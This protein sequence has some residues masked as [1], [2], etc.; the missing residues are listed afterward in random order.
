MHRF[1]VDNKSGN[2]FILDEDTKKHIK[3]VRIKKESFLINHLG[4]YYECKLSENYEFANI[5]KKLDINNEFAYD[6][7]LLAPI[8][9]LKRFEWLIQ[10]ATELGVKKIVPFISKFTNW[11]ELEQ[12][13]T[14]KYDRFNEIILNASQQSFRN[15]V[16]LLEKHD[17]LENV[18]KRYYDL[19][20]DVFLA[21]EQASKNEEIKID[22]K[23]LII[24]VGPEGGFSIDEVNKIIEITNK[25]AK[26]VSLGKTILRAETACIYMLSQLPKV[27]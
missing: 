10:K 3:S 5:I 16:P 6:T 8:I 27:Y 15:Y 24:I 22:P 14:K 17:H 4:I 20:Y 23:N 21:Y 26:I 19:N 2:K 13:F 7:V 1:F 11:K 18:V 25:K 9:D 12:Q